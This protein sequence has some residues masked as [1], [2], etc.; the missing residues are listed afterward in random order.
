MRSIGSR[1]RTLTRRVQRWLSDLDRATRPVD[2]EVARA[3]GSRWEQLPAGV[4]TPSQMLGRKFAGCEATHGVFPACNFGCR[5][6]YLPR[7]SSRVRLDA[8]HTLAQI[9]RQMAYLSEQ[10][11]P[12]QYAQLIGGEVSLLPPEV[13]ARAL[14]VM[15][16]HGRF[17]MSFT[18]GDFDYDY[19]ERL[20]VRPDGSPRFDLV[21]FAV[22]V[23]STM[24]GRRAVPRPSCESELH[25][26]RRRIRAMFE[27][28]ERD[29]GVRHHLAHSMTVTP[30]NIDQVADVV[31]VCRELGFRM[32]SFQP[33]AEVG[34][35]RRWDGDYRSIDDDRVWA[36]IERGVGRRLPHRA[37]EVGDPRCNRVT[38][39]L[40]SRTRFVPV[41]EDDDPRDL[42][43]RDAF[44]RVLPGNLLFASRPRTVLR[45]ARA[46][47]AHPRDLPVA[48]GWAVR[49]ARRLGVG[50]L[51]GVRPATYVMHSFM[52]AADV[53]AA[54]E[55]LERDEAAT[56]PRIRATQER[57]RAC[58]YGMAHPDR[59]QIVPACVQHSV[60][61]ETENTHL[62][63][64]LPL[65]R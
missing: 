25:A 10:R 20:A 6:C 39:G 41:V 43:A 15:R 34:D 64:R 19:L 4:R 52:H 47:V 45:V 16:R 38:W 21:S 53:R 42:A 62:M 59:D 18:H 2:R 30:A 8:E 63:R 40:W 54:W 46:L 57:L 36:Q 58:A 3:L 17:P 9:E 1:A 44:L 31:R 11:G 14:E 35:E 24:R 61:D 13:H 55:L 65:Q 56:D 22:H 12:A 49:L 7:N 26:E 37:L 51:A 48:L 33:A 23:D 28:L 60:L 27:R 29:H 5:P 32:C 50:A